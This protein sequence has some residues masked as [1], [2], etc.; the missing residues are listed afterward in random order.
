MLN[1]K[2]NNGK[3][4]PFRKPTTLPSHDPITLVHKLMKID[5]VFTTSYQIWLKTEVFQSYSILRH[6]KNC[7]WNVTKVIKSK[8]FWLSDTVHSAV[9]YIQS[10]RTDYT[11]CGTLTV[12]SS[13]CHNFL[14]TLLRF[15]QV[16]VNKAQKLVSSFYMM[17]VK[18]RTIFSLNFNY[19]SGFFSFMP[20]NRVNLV[21]LAS[22]CVDVLFWAFC[23]KLSLQ[24]VVKLLR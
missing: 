22:F 21:K 14:R 16:A 9:W 10:L 11:M 17:L 23:E 12:E 3:T 1:L 20:Q 7:Q 18:N 13:N 8:L 6:K 15:L 19:L 5:V 2:I 24:K 4:L